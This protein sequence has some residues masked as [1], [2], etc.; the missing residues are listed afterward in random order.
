[1]KDQSPH[2]T[3][4]VEVPVKLSGTLRVSIPSHLDAEEFVQLALKQLSERI[5][6]DT[7][8]G[9]T[10]TV[11]YEYVADIWSP[12]RQANVGEQMFD[13]QHD[14]SQ[15]VSGAVVA[16]KP[17][18]GA[19]GENRYRSQIGAYVAEHDV[20]VTARCP[21]TGYER[22]IV[23]VRMNDGEPTVY[24]MDP[25]PDELLSEDGEVPLFA[26]AFPGMSFAIN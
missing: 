21:R 6:A 9:E 19:F 18:K 2:N 15:N 26:A 23:N 8:L 14:L 12:E 24:V 5:S 11:T 7:A 3:Q 25:S 16:L 1:M 10:G 20:Y 4:V 13:M 22:V 17:R